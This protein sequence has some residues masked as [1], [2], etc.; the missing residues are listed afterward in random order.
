MARV[1]IF[2]FL[3]LWIVGYTFLI[4]HTAQ[5]LHMCKIEQKKRKH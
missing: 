2:D 3:R 1:A 5:M 4:Q